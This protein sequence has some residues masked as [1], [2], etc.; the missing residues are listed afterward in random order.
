[1][2]S[3][4]GS[5]AK[6]IYLPRLLGSAAGCWAVS[7]VLNDYAMPALVWVLL[8]FH[9]FIWPHVAYL[10]GRKVPVPYLVECRNMYRRVGIWRP[11]GCGHAVQRPP[12]HVAGV[13]VLH[14]LHRRWWPA[15]AGGKPADDGLDMRSRLRFSGVIVSA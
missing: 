6:R 9:G 14:E 7:V 1:M 12:L 5:F 10:L 3:K 2:T 11:M 8:V 4:P 13:H 15:T